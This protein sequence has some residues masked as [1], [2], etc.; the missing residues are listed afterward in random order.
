MAEK[1]TISDK[2]LLAV[3]RE[4]DGSMRDAQTLLDQVIAYGGGEVDDEVVA[5][6]LDLIDRNL[7]LAILAACVAGDASQA[8]TACA[9]WL[10]AQ[11]PTRR[12]REQTFKI[13]RRLHRGDPVFEG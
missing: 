7:L 13:A 10:A 11:Y 4:G 12:A 1:V 2:S 3:A 9:R 6:V 8:L 5:D